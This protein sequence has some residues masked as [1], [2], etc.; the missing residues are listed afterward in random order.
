[1]AH[2]WQLER[3]GQ[4]HLQWVEAAT[5]Q[6]GPGEVLVRVSAVAL[7]YR[8]LLMLQDGMGMQVPMPFVPGSDL[9]GTVVGLGAGVSR[10]RE[11]ERVISTFWPGW[12]DGARAAEAVPLGGPG[13]GMLASHVVLHQ[14]GL[15]RA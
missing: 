1:M 15:V 12:V 2:R 4:E 7:N 6:P 14:D 5:P 10:V 9:C 11:G 8:D 13:P 3:F